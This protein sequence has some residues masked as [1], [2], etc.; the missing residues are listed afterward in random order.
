[1]NENSLPHECII[2]VGLWEKYF[3]GQKFSFDLNY[4]HSFM[5]DKI[6][7]LIVRSLNFEG[8]FENR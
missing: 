3:N 6:N 2:R 5:Y 7:K 1:M 4:D 8:D